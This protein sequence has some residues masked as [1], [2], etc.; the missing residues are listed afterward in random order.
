MSKIDWSK[1]L[2]INDTVKD[3]YNDRFFSVSG[4]YASAP[5][6]LQLTDCQFFYDCYFDDLDENFLKG[7]YIHRLSPI[8]KALTKDVK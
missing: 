4:F 5:D 7:R 1:I 2:K 8:Y 6:R 3:R